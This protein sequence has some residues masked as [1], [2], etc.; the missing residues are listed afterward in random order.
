MVFRVHYLDGNVSKSTTIPSQRILHSKSIDW[1]S[2]SHR[3]SGSCALLSHV[4]RDF[5]NTQLDAVIIN[6]T[7]P[8]SNPDTVK[9][10][11]F[12]IEDRRNNYINIKNTI[13]LRELYIRAT[14]LKIIENLSIVP[15]KDTKIGVK[16]I[17]S[18]FDKRLTELEFISTLSI[19]SLTPMNLKDQI[20]TWVINTQKVH[21][22][23]LN[24]KDRFYQYAEF[25]D[26]VHQI[27]NCKLPSKMSR[28]AIQSLGTIMNYID[29]D[30][31]EEIYENIVQENVDKLWD[32]IKN[33]NMRS[34]KVYTLVLGGI[35]LSIGNGNTH[36]HILGTRYELGHKPTFKTIISLIE[37]IGLTNK[38]RNGLEREI[39]KRS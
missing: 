31:F 3:K 23:I 20:R 26:D 24:N 35:K 1:I 39:L 11:L 22:F 32:Q 7:D 2:I 34:D 28:S 33:I 13:N 27:C 36:A 14:P 29:C 16:L 15:Y 12:D 9:H 18:I 38:F 10:I 25:R 4:R 6:T 30:H 8:K 19:T 21:A 37:M 5:R 17:F